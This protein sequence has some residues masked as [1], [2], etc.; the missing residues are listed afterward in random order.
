LPPTPTALPRSGPLYSD[1]LGINFISSA[2]HEGSDGRFR[3][4]LNTG[5]GWDRFAIYWSDVEREQGS[6]QWGLYDEAVRNDVRYN[7][8]TDA[9]LL[10][11]PRAHADSRNVPTNL[12]EPV[13]SDGTDTPGAGKLINPNNPWARFV[14]AAVMRYKPGGEMALAEGWTPRQGVRVW[15]IWNE[16]DLNNFWG[17]TTEEYARLLKVAYLAVRHADSKAQ[18]MVGGLALFAKPYFLIEMLNA[19]KHDPSPVSGVYPFDIMAVHAYN[20]PPYTF[21]AV[22]STRNTLAA[23]GLNDMP[24]WVNE[25]GVPVWDDYPGPSWATRPDQI[26]FRATQDEQASYVIQNAAYAYMAGAKVVF[27]FQLYDDCGNQPAGTTFAPH[28]GSLCDS[29]APCWGDALG[30]MR[31]NTDNLCFNQHPRP[32]TARPA[33]EAFHNV[34]AVFG[35][36]PFTPIA[37]FTAGESG[38]QQWLIF[39]RPGSAELITVIWN[40]SGTISEALVPATSSGAI[41]ID[42]LGFQTALKPEGDGMYHLH[43]LP[44]TNQNQVNMPDVRYMI[45][46]PPVILVEQSPK[47]LVSVLP[48]LER[49]PSAILVEWRASL[50]GLTVF[51]VWYR[52]ESG[53][54]EWVRWLETDGPTGALFIGAPGHRYSFFARAQAPDGSWSADT[55]YPQATTTVVE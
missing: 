41:L 1:V 4:G 45:G 36:A 3:M 14:Y 31:N 42:I 2:Q 54:G 20:H 22:Q 47:P 9:I 38:A 6:F 17:G 7:L 34:G 16:P 35:A 43:L 18:V 21:W 19:Y 11:T 26:V 29:G 25:S 15:E 50:P 48:L 28:D 33:Y 23:F 13:F 37:E 49:S 27:H 40:N 24:I 5:A 39:A 46:G 51:E 52:D 30:L 53:T 55:P 12:G 32:N 44:A 8:R 10:G